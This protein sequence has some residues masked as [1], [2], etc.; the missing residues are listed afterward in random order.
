[1]QSRRYNVYSTRVFSVS[2]R[3]AFL[4]KMFDAVSK[5]R[6]QQKKN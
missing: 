6:K 4:D 3:G 5:D 1:M 2:K